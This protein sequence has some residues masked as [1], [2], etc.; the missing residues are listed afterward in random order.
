MME[1]MKSVGES[2][3]NTKSAPPLPVIGSNITPITEEG[4]K[5][6]FG[7]QK[8]TQV[9]YTVWFSYP[10]Q[11]QKE[12]TRLNSDLQQEIPIINQTMLDETQS[13]NEIEITKETRIAL[14]ARKYAENQFSLEESARLDILTEKVRRLI[15][16]IT[17]KDREKMEDLNSRLTTI[18]T[19]NNEIRRK[20]RLEK[21]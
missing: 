2:S 12:S 7:G 14:L 13:H 4:L 15:P 1:N 9:S 16:S 19:V 17:D 11:G 10:S 5:S 18:S 8:D 21:D 3:T 20:Y 6:H